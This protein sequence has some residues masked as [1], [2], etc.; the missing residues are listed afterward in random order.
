MRFILFWIV[1]NFINEKNIQKKLNHEKREI[2]LTLRKSANKDQF[3]FEMRYDNSNYEGFVK[4]QN[5]NL[6]NML[7]NSKYIDLKESN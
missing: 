2:I 1:F 4:L 7:K 5:S 6:S 3:D